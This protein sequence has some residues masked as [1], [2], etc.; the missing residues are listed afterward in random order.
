MGNIKKNYADYISYLNDNTITDSK[1]KSLFKDKIPKLLDNK[2]FITE[3][4]GQNGLLL[5]YASK[6]LKG[7]FDTVLKAVQQN[8]DAF[9]FASENLKNNKD[10]IYAAIISAKSSVLKFVP[11]KFL[12][13]K[14]LILEAIKYRPEELVYAADKLKNDLLFLVKCVKTNHRAYLYIPKQFIYDSELFLALLSKLFGHSYVSG[15]K[16]YSFESLVDQTLEF[17]ST[18]FEYIPIEYRRNRNIAL[19]AIKLDDNTITYKILNEEFK[20]DRQF[21]LISLALT[22]RYSIKTLYEELPAHFKNDIV[23]IKLILSLY[24]NMFD[25]IPNEIIK[26]NDIDLANIKKTCKDYSSFSNKKYE[27]FS[28]ALKNNREIA[29]I[30]IIK[31]MGSD[32]EFLPYYLKKDIEIIR[33]SL[34]LNGEVINDMP[35]KIKD[36]N[37]YALIAIKSKGSALRFLSDKYKKDKEF[38]FKALKNGASIEYLDENFKNDKE[39]VRKATENNWREFEFASDSLRND[40][41]L[42]QQVIQATHSID[43]KRYLFRYL[44]EKLRNNKKFCLKL[45]SKDWGLFPA[46]N[47]D[48]KDDMDILIEAIKQNDFAIHWASERLK[49]KQSY[50]FKNFYKLSGATNVENDGYF[51]SNLKKYRAEIEAFTKQFKIKLTPENIDRIEYVAEGQI[52]YQL[53]DRGLE[54]NRIH[55]RS[56]L[57]FY[58]GEECIK[59][60]GGKW[61]WEENS[62]NEYYPYYV[63]LNS[64][65]K[66]NPFILIQ[67]R[68]DPDNQDVG[69]IYNYYLECDKTEEEIKKE[70]V[71]KDS[72]NEVFSLEKLILETDSIYKGL[73]PLTVEECSVLDQDTLL[74]IYKTTDLWG[75]GSIT[76]HEIKRQIK[77][78]LKKYGRIS[79]EYIIS[80]IDKNKFSEHDKNIV[81]NN[82]KSID[83]LNNS[84]ISDIEKQSFAD[85]NVTNLFDN[86]EF[87]LQAVLQNGLLL[88]YASKKKQDNYDIVFEAVQQNV[89]ALKFSSDKLLN[90]KKIISKAISENKKENYNNMEIILKYVPEKLRETKYIIFDAIQ[91]NAKEFKYASNNLKN[92]IK[93]ILK[94]IKRN[95]YIYFYLSDSLKKNPVIFRELLLKTQGFGRSFV[96]WEIDKKRIKSF[97]KMVNIAIKWNGLLLQYLPSDLRNDKEIALLAVSS[98]NGGYEIPYQYLS[99]ELKNDREISKLSIKNSVGGSY[100]FMPSKLINDAEII[101]LVLKE[102]RTKFNSFPKEYKNNRDF[103]LKAI[104]NHISVLLEYLDDSLRDDSEIVLSTIKYKAYQFQYAS[105]RLRNDEAVILK[106]MQICNNPEVVFSYSSE[107]LRSNKEFCVLALKIEWSCIKFINEQLK[108]DDDIILA[109]METSDYAI[110]YASKRIKEKEEDF[111]NNYYNLAGITNLQKNARFQRELQN[112]LSWLE[113]ETKYDWRIKLSIKNIDEILQEG[114]NTNDRKV[115]RIRERDKNQLIGSLGFYLG[116]QFINEVG[117]KWRVEDN[118]KINKYPYYVLLDNGKSSN[119]FVFVKSSVAKW[120]DKMKKYQD[121]KVPYPTSECL[122]KYYK[123]II[124]TGQS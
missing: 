88:K 91:Y 69:P 4:V 117:G 29:I 57:G 119:P 85:N 32:F 84:S 12:S 16:H 102:N 42:I 24:D 17:N 111:I 94:C 22:N 52:G 50:I 49:A 82:Q 1:K 9:E 104:K 18:I 11:E 80:L 3:A 35:N 61:E 79:M 43:S 60:A 55:M 6:K 44:P 59:K 37:D 115:E 64:E 21:V 74:K 28:E 120:R 26:T 107:Q 100:Q 76:Y 98:A 14:K 51:N 118:P 62:D 45:I 110:K 25:E 46:L 13:I 34:F 70:K 93:F 67:N 23:V 103:V 90:N 15:R 7:D 96:D 73:Q 86:Y 53:S 2:E 75:K 30:S 78:E 116:E 33:L 112:E 19:K 113:S 56:M 81:I 77:S 95:M 10:I 97:S 87:V 108:D 54:A 48:L 66:F 27:S 38:V 72:V 99:E 121:N 36:N 124:R 71:K 31:S 92:D 83:F 39:I 20:N 41:V 40:K 101:E 5:K 106:A 89:L 58:L 68:L 109:A 122:T 63:S 8:G 65:K 114:V 105:A 47:K 123:D